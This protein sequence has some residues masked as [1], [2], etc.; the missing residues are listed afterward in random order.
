MEKSLRCGSR[1]AM[2]TEAGLRRDGTLAG[3]C[4]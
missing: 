2:S 4:A 3:T 1:L